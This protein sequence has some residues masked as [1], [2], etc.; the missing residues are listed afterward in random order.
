MPSSQ[1]ILKNYPS[2]F[3]KDVLDVLGLM[4]LP[5]TFRTALL[6]SS[7]LKISYASDFDAYSEVNIT[8]TTT[9]EFQEA[10]TKIMNFRVKDFTKMRRQDKAI[11]IGDIKAGVVERFRIVPE[12]LTN[13]NWNSSLNSMLLKSKNMF[14]QKIIN[15]YEYDTAI[16]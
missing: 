5:N 14:N 1:V 13:L 16:R 10:I 2:D 8:Q 6:G 15:K 9:Q 3:S 12:D 11:Y 7:A 4:T